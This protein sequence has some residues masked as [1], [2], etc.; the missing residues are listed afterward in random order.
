MVNIA[1]TTIG[2]VASIVGGASR[3]SILIGHHYFA[4]NN[5]IAVF[6]F[7]MKSKR[8]ILRGKR[9]QGVPATT[10][11]S[12]GI[13]TEQ[14]GAVDWLRIAAIPPLSVDFKLAYRVQ[15]AGGKNPATC[16]GMPKYFEVQ[17]ATE[18]CKYLRDTGSVPMA[19][20]NLL[21]S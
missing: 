11:A 21:F 13:P 16:K 4:P 6:D 9:D 2:A 17:Y 14:N 1:K 8:S 12:K 20:V 5:T 15:T 10:T 7:R 3:D 19:R 18:Y